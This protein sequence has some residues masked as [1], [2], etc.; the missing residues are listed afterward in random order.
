MKKNINPILLLGAHMPITKGLTEAIEDGESLG[1]TTIQIFTKSSRQWKGKTLSQSNISAF[2]ARHKQSPI[3]P[4][5]AH[6]SYLINIGSP[7]PLTLEKSID[8]LR[9]ELKRCDDLGVDFLV[10]HPGSALKSTEEECINKIAESINTVFDSI[11]TTSML[12]LETTAGQGTNVGYTFEHL[13]DIIKQIKDKSRIG[14]CLDTC[15]IYAAGYDL[16]NE[17]TYNNVWRNFESIVGLRYLKAIH[18]NDSAQGL[19]SKKDRHAHIGKGQIGMEGFRLLMND[20]QL[21]NIPKVLE[22]PKDSLK[23][24]AINLGLLVNLVE[25]K[26]K[27]LV[28]K[29][30]LKKY[31]KK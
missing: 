23:E 15:H 3:G 13:R 10:F 18:L 2:R 31:T 5:M 19:G 29:T 11:K 20:P 6:A 14:V 26:N 17:K 21:F 7:N 27:E 30:P 16:S 24:D 22:T 8:A 28:L 1:C 4:I 25:S 12:L 9:E